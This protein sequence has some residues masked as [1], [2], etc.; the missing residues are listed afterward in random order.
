MVTYG[1][2]CFGILAGLLIASPFFIVMSAPF[3]AGL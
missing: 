3:V 2:D 1:S